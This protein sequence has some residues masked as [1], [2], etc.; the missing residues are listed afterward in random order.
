VLSLL[1]A[2]SGCASID[3]AN[4]PRIDGQIEDTEWKA[5][6]TY[7]I[8][9][10][11]TV[12]LIRRSDNL[13][14]AVSAAETGFP[15]IFVGDAN[16]VSVLH[17]SAAQASLTY[18]RSGNTW[19]PL[20]PGF[21]Y[22]LRRG[23]DGSQASDEMRHAFFARNGWLSTSDLDHGPDREFVVQVDSERRFLAISILGIP[24]MRIHGWPADAEDDTQ[25]PSLLRG[26][27]PSTL[28]FSPESWQ[29]IGQ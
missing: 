7:L 4:V 9:G 29:S 23:P 21:E 5:A 14:I 28:S 18:V 12:R 8:P 1:F 24:S 22:A 20:A 10:G 3:A 19:T 13:Y 11:G 15:T 16:T 25:N 6:S 2:A 27:V 17:A 26:E